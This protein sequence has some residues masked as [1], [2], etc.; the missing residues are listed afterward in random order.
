MPE[1]I[2][3][4]FL[5]AN[6]SDDNRRRMEEE[7]REIEGRIRAGEY[8]ARFDFI[9][10]GAVRPRDLQQILLRHRPHIVHLSGLGSE[11]QGLV[12]TDDDD[13]SE[14][15]G[16]Q[17]L[18][19]LFEI[20]KDNVR[21]VIFNADYAERQARGLAG[22]VD[23]VIGMRGAMGAAG[24]VIFST[25]FYQALA[26]GRTVK[27]AFELAKN[28]LEIEGK[29]G[30]EM[31]A[32]WTR[33]GVDEAQSFLT[34]ESKTGLA[35]AEVAST[36]NVSTALVALR[37][38]RRLSE[39]TAQDAQ[40]ID[41]ND[42][43]LGGELRL[44]QLYVHRTVEHRINCL[45]SLEKSVPTFILIVGDAGHGK[46]SLLWQLYRSL[47]KSQGWEPWF[48]KSTLYLNCREQQLTPSRPDRELA[49][50]SLL[51]TAQFAVS[52]GLRPVVFLDTVDLLLRSEADRHFLLE[53]IS[54]LLDLDCF[55]VATCRPQEAVGLYPIRAAN[56]VLREYVDDEEQNEFELR[57]AIVK[58]AERFYA[59]P[60]RKNYPVNVQDILDSVARGLPLREVCAN[61]LTLRMLF[62]IYAPEAVT[63]DINIFKEKERSYEKMQYWA[64]S[65]LTKIN[66]KP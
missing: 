50:D 54:T 60:I 52:Q 28:E 8:G 46:T 15:V 29:S 17:A 22:V 31:L 37:R 53:L 18:A 4:L 55:V 56:I 42:R 65:H 59:E 30:S 34:P 2:R 43:T 20:L 62:T 64:L 23:Y 45:L 35:A 13:D 47:D 33:E 7:A 41:Y 58:H 10:K 63:N 48:I 19:R 11:G 40:F 21:L 49:T 66:S 16:P 32:L 61:P 51:R 3:I 1:R 14:S 27:A 57:E 5:A 12:L 6:S 25:H 36:E 39:I 24:A 9:P 26:Y 44:E 38:M